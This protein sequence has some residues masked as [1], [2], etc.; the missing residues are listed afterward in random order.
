MENQTAEI[1]WKDSGVRCPSNS[2]S[3]LQS[4]I[5]GVEENAACPFGATIWRNRLPRRVS[6]IAELGFGNRAEFS[7][8]LGTHG[9]AR[10]EEGALHFPRSKPSR[11]RRRYGASA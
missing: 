6:R 7:R 2:M 8:G 1:E 3:V 11:C 10:R 9:C 4:L 5:N